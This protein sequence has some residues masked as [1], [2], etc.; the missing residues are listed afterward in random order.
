MKRNKGLFRRLLAAVMAMALLAGAMPG[1][2]A[3]ADGEEAS[4]FGTVSAAEAGLSVSGNGTGVVTVSNTGLLTLDWVKD[5]GTRGSDGWWIGCKVTA[6][7]GMSAEELEKAKF[8]SGGT[9][10]EFWKYKDSKDS[11]S[12]QYI[13][14]YGLLT[15]EYLKKAGERTLRYTWQFNW[16]GDDRFEQKVILE[17]SPDNV[18]LKNEDGSR[19]F[20][21]A[22][23]TLTSVPAGTQTGEAGEETVLTLEGTEIPFDTAKEKWHIDITVTAPKH[24][25]SALE[26]GQE[27]TSPTTYELELTPDGEND[28]VS[29]E[30][31]RSFQWDGVKQTMKVVAKDVV[32]KKADQA[33]LEFAVAAPDPQLMKTGSYTNTARGGSVEG[34]IEYESSDANVAAVDKS[35]GVVTFVSPGTVIITAKL[36][37]NEYYNDVTG[38]YSLTLMNSKWGLEWENPEPASLVYGT[39]DNQFR[40]TAQYLNDQGEPVSDGVLYEITESQA[41]GDDPAEKVA[42]VSEDGTLTILHTGT[43]TVS[44]HKDAAAGYDEEEISYTLEIVPGEQTISIKAE[45]AKND[46]VILYHADEEYSYLY[47][48]SD[49]T[50]E[51]ETTVS[52]SNEAVAAAELR[53]DGKVVVT[54]RGNGSF[55]L[56]VSNEGDENYK[57]AE[58]TKEI[59]VLIEESAAAFEKSGDQTVTYGNAFKNALINIQGSGEVTYKSGDTNVAEVSEDGAV[60][61]VKAGTVTITA[62]KQADDV[63]G[64]VELRYTLTINKAEQTV[65]FKDKELELVTGNKTDFTPD[66]AETGAGNGT[67]TY[68]VDEGATWL[69]SFNEKTGA[70]T[71]KPGATGTVT[72]RAVKA[73]DDCYNEAED[74]CTLTVV[75]ADIPEEPYTL[76][77]EK[78][79]PDNDWFIGDVAIQPREGYEILACGENGALPDTLEWR[80]QLTNSA[81]GEWS[82]VI[83]LRDAGGGI[84]DSIHVE[85]IRIDKTAPEIVSIDYR[86][87][88]LDHILEKLTFGYYQADV[89]VTIHAEDSVSGV[90]SIHYNYNYSKQGEEE[91]WDDASWKAAAPDGNGDVEFT[92]TPEY[93]GK[94]RFYAENNA[95]LKTKAVTDDKTLV[96]DN[97][98]PK[99]KVTWSDPITK[100]TWC[101]SEKAVATV[102]VEEAFFYGEDVAISGGAFDG[103]WEMALD[104]SGAPIKNTWVNTVTLK[105]EGHHVL[106]IRYSDRSGNGMTDFSGNRLDPY[107]SETII[108][109]RTPPVLKLTWSNET[110]VDGDKT[111]YYPDKAVATVVITEKNFFDGGDVKISGGKFDSSWKAYRNEV[112]EPVADAWVNTVTLDSEGGHALNITYTDRS[113]NGM[114]DSFGNKLDPYTS[115]TV[116]IDH[117]DPV[118]TASIDTGGTRQYFKEAQTVTVTVAEK[119]FDASLVKVDIVSQDSSGANVDSGVTFGQWTDK[120]GNVYSQEIVFAGDANYTVNIGCKDKSGREDSVEAQSFTVDKTAPG[121]MSIAYSTSVFGQILGGISFGYYNAP[122]TVTLSAVDPGAGI[123]SFQYQYALNGGVSSVNAGGSGVVGATRSGNTYTASFQIPGDALRASNQFN[124]YV[125]FS[126]ADRSGNRSTHSTRGSQTVIVDSISPTATVTYNEPAKEENG[127]SYYSQN[128]EGT[129]S[130]REANFDRNDVAVNVTKNGAEYRANVNWTDSSADDHTGRFTLTE[131]GDY[132]VSISYTDKSGNA[133]TEYTSHRLTLD[134][135]APEIRVTGIV[136]NSANQDDTYGFSVTVEDIN[137]DVKEMKPVLQAVLRGEDGRYR[138]ETIELGEPAEVTANQVYTYTVENLPEDALYTLTCQAADLA[139]NIAENLLLEDGKAYE[140]VRFS[141]NRNGS[142]FGFGD[143][144]TENVVN[145]YYVYQ[146][147]KDLVIVEVNVDPIE[148]YSVLLNGE[149]LTEGVDYDTEQ[150][151]EPGQWSKRTYTIHKQRLEAEGEYSIVV[152]SKDKTKTTAYSDVKNLAVAFVVDQTEPALTITGVESGGRYQTS[153]QTVTVIPT[154]EG[155]RLRTMTVRVL[156][157]RGNPLTDEEGKDISVRFEMNGEAFLKYL[158]EHDGKVTFTVPEGLNLKVRID[159]DDCAV[160][161]DGTTNVFSKT[162]EKVTVSQNRFVIFYANTPLLIGSIAG[163]LA[164]AALIVFLLMRRKGKVAA[165]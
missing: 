18:L 94:V 27:F 66:M 81:E 26:E 5:N 95:G 46:S 84:T 162:F 98:P 96:V 74:S 164:A 49:I 145:Q 1:G 36:A 155:G 111:R 150:S 65:A 29:G 134:T 132:I 75:Y 48:V 15:P 52:S 102:T 59:T 6:P 157:A 39:N 47:T 3:A 158:E 148:E 61:I 103:E 100:G 156:D 54:P 142:V 143:A 45:D 88:V 11:D 151:S 138:T 63:Y 149:A 120:G 24:I 146:V 124:G 4:G 130:I 126:A 106:E 79:V 42:E 67:I 14:M 131:D 13:W 101:Y 50:S 144:E 117:T 62:T 109:D 43:V 25:S 16:D 76:V 112:G 70:V 121:G 9:E 133:M 123:E 137:L 129:I 86:T 21:S 136:A 35:S 91:F 19:A 2:A 58:G 17:I 73:E 165:K 41:S 71:W 57:P 125:T 89:I 97:T 87:S 115:E 33:P 110:T 32:L 28:T 92:I 12:E 90:A 64:P 128:I 114:T 135:E 44:A 147:P 152:A 118:I 40:N 72:I 30:W 105:S 159:C 116:V 22:Y 99:M 7:S 69:D 20:P 80:E 23:G 122:V 83:R 8:I 161:T 78:S 139:G 60:T 56:T 93:E 10:K 53:E 31:S 160:K 119:N 127:V 68:S 77:G 51:G 37:G 34:S 154:D 163:V 141:I 85:E 55:T 140:A 38:S 108:V 153:Q 82:P 104:E 107:T 113:G